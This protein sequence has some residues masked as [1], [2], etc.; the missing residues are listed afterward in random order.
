MTNFPIDPERLAAFVDGRLPEHERAKVLEEIAASPE[1]YDLFMETVGAIDGAEEEDEGSVVPLAAAPASRLR[2]WR[3][4]A[5]LAAAVAGVALFGTWLT[6]P[7][8]APSGALGFAAALDAGLLAGRPGGE[9]AGADHGWSRVRGPGEADESPARGFRVGVRQVD[10]AV[11]IRLEDRATLEIVAPLLAEDLA[12]YDGGQ[13]GALLVRQIADS[14][15]S[16]A[17]VETLERLA[18]EAEEAAASAVSSPAHEAGRLAEAGRIAARAGDTRFL[19]GSAV[20]GRL[21]A[22]DAGTLG[23]AAATLEALRARLGADPAPSP[24]EL[25]PLLEALVQAGGG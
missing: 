17:A 14:A 22:L 1:A 6:R 10:L 7:G 4:P 16:G 8:E 25:M 13:V 21:A 18:G 15:A 2:R 20:L 9:L 23:P 24:G 12:R 3:V 5:T 11:A 19:E